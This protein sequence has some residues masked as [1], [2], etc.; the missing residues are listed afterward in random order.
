MTCLVIL[1]EPASVAACELAGSSGTAAV[2]GSALV[3]SPLPS[4]GGPGLP[5]GPSSGAV[6]LAVAGGA[7]AQPG[8]AGGDAAVAPKPGSPEPTEPSAEARAEARARA[9]GAP[10]LETPAA[11][12]PQETACA[13]A[14]SGVVSRVAAEG[15]GSGSPRRARAA[16]RWVQVAPEVMKERD[17]APEPGL[18]APLGARAPSQAPAPEPVL[19]AKAM[20]ARQG[21]P[22]AGLLLCVDTVGAAP[23]L[24]PRPDLAPVPEAAA[25]QA[26]PLAA[27]RRGVGSEALKLGLGSDLGPGSPACAPPATPRLLPS[28]WA[29]ISR[30]LSPSPSPSPSAGKHLAADGAFD[31]DAGS[32]GGTAPVAGGVEQ[33]T[34]NERSG[35]SEVTTPA[36]GADPQ[37][38]SHAVP[39]DAAQGPLTGACGDLSSRGSAGGGP[40]RAP[41]GKG[42]GGAPGARSGALGTASD[43]RAP[44]RPG[45]EKACEGGPE[46]GTGGGGGQAGRSGSAEGQAAPCDESGPAVM[47]LPDGNKVG[48]GTAELPA[49]L[50]V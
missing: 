8:S 32:R 14:G 2:P 3:G 18:A 4:P 46:V 50:A 12:R 17:L 5:A 45:G 29:R 39:A 27:L 23:D 15:A 21:A 22:S 40:W 41:A 16:P 43:A 19:L 26:A 7:A 20:A 30:T 44:E 28:G 36:A 34:S 24:A 37:V 47:E 49:L 31:P 13:E 1:Q 11:C 38:P 42:G 35:A 33:G 9:P 48:S 6:T 25:V 10:G